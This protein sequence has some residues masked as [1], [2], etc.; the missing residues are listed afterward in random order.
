MNNKVGPRLGIVL[1]FQD[2][3]NFY[4][5]YR[6]VGNP[7]QV[8]ISKVVNGVETVL[9]SGS[10]WNPLKGAFFKLGCQAKGTT[11]TLSLDGIAKLSVSDS[12]FSSGS[13]GMTMG[14]PTSAAGK[15]SSH[16]ADN[17]SA[18]LQ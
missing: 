4:L 8:G 14:Y 7:T 16:R 3:K 5:A 18:T 17:F 2:P 15:V 6:Q 10:I 1:R 9:K 11:L 12:A 13:A